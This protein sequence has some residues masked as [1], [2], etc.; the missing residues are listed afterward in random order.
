L[1]L[2]SNNFL[3]AIHYLLRRNT[4][5][6][7]LKYSFTFL[8]IEGFIN[9]QTMVDAFKKR[10]TDASTAP[11]GTFDKYSPTFGLPAVVFTRLSADFPTSAY[12]EYKIR[13]R[14][15]L[16]GAESSR[17]YLIL[18]SKVYIYVSILE[19]MYLLLYS[20]VYVFITLF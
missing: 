12:V 20:R 5:H 10:E 1:K 16:Y 11:D 6:Y 8:G 3:T 17:M 18:Y 7:L 15:V 4:I 2:K 9:E 19:C 13:P 14:V